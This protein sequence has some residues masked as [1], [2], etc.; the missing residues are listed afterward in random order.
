MDIC[1][2][3][4]VPGFS[5]MQNIKRSFFA[6]R[7]GVVADALKKGGAPFRIIFGLN[8]PQ[9]VQIA[10]SAP[11]SKTLA[12]LLWANTSTRES[13]LLAPMLMPREEFSVSDALV[14]VTQV[15]SVEVADVLCHRLLRYLPFAASLASDILGKSNAAPLERYTA[16]RLLLNII[17]INPALVQ[18]AADEERKR[19][20]ALTAPLCAQ[21][22]DE[23]SFL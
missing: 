10:E 2:L 19:N 8:L 16:L 1:K 7:N 5:D 14:W 11:K 6:L 9:I 22:A 18:Q 17:R 21:I 13:L 12:Q 3:K 15:P 20:C 4:T 23:L